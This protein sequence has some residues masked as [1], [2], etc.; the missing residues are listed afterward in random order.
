MYIYRGS[1]AT[2]CLIPSSTPCL[3]FASLIVCF[4]SS[5]PRSTLPRL[6]LFFLLF[7]YSA[8]QFQGQKGVYG[9]K[10]SIISSE[11]EP[12]EVKFVDINPAEGG[13]KGKN[14][15]TKLSLN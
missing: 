2:F 6:S 12:T 13:R 9:I 4:D 14:Q 10:I 11:D 1:W 8:A 15:N 5:P 3:C 7:S